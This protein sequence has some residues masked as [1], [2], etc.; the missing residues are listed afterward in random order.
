MAIVH[1]AYN[2]SSSLFFGKDVIQPAEGV[3]LGDPIGPLLF[4]LSIHDV[5]LPLKS[6]FLAFYLDDGIPG[7]SVEE[8]LHDLRTVEGVAGNIGL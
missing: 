5:L 3:R 7:G 4:C 6:V 1:S 8:V 2:S